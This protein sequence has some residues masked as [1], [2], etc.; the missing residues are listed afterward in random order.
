MQRRHAVLKMLSCLPDPPLDCS[1]RPAKSSRNRFA[2]KR[3]QAVEFHYLTQVVWQSIFV[4]KFR[5]EI[6][7]HFCLGG[8]LPS[9]AVLWIREQLFTA[10]NL[11]FHSSYIPMKQLGNI[12]ITHVFYHAKR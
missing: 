7:Y 4:S 6:R 3:L 2:A 10:M 9:I 11:G 5:L 1:L 12:P 8:F